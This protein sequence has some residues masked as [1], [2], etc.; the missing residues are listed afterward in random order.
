MKTRAIILT[1]FIMSQ[2][3]GFAQDAKEAQLRQFAISTQAGHFYDLQYTSFDDLMN[4]AS[5][6]DMRGL[7]GLNTQ[8]DVG[9][10]ARLHYYYSPLVSFELGYDNASITGANAVEWHTSSNNA[11][12]LSM[13]IDMK[14]SSTIEE[15]TT[16]PFLRL[17]MGML[18]YSSERSFVSDGII[19][20]NTRGTSTMT[21]YG[22]GV[23]HHLN[24]VISLNVQSMLR[25]I[26]TDAWDGYDYSSGRDHVLYTTVGVE[27]AFGTGGH[28]NRKPSYRDSRVNQL[29]N[30]IE[31]LKS[32]DE[33]IYDLIDLNRE[34]SER[35]RKDLELMKLGVEKLAEEQ[36]GLT[37]SLQ[38]EEFG[39]YNIYYDFNN[40]NINEFFVLELQKRVF[41]LEGQS[42]VFRL[43]AFSDEKGTPLANK[44]IRARR[45]QKAEELLKTWGI[46]KENIEI[47]PWDGSYTGNDI[48]D[49]RLEISVHV[50]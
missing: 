42:V 2:A 11:F 25:I 31:S 23:Q 27:Y 21:E 9:F 47:K 19:F 3:T 44:L 15:Y 10:A 1:A 36:V 39:A 26:H 28:M 5:G 37:K 20:S 6:E 18:N 32:S 13:K 41:A 50:M 22:V 34:E 45:L 40:A 35:F 38:K 24:D 46:S 12:S 14:K 29:I 30:E 33:A 8:F 17:G 48:L 43:Q 16:I 7:N 4:G 49:R